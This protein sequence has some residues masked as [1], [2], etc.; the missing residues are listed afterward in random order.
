MF[1]NTNTVLKASEFHH[2]KTIQTS[3]LIS[4]ESTESG[5]QNLKHLLQ[6]W[7]F[8]VEL[9]FIELINGSW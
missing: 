8:E 1:F 4:D 3:Q 6:T 9:I 7:S 2:Q 5:P